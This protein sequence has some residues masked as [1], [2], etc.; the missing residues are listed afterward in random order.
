LLKQVSVINGIAE[1][2]SLENS[3][4]R[5]F[6]YLDSMV[7]KD[8]QPYFNVFMTVPAEAAHDWPDF[9]D[10]MSRQLQ[11]AVFAGYMTGNFP[12]NTDKWYEKLFS[13]IDKD[14]GL[15]YRPETDYS[16][17]EADPGDQA[18]TLF[19]LVTL[20]EQI[21]SDHIITTAMKMTDSLSKIIGSTERTD[22]SWLHGFAI[23]SLMVFYR[24][25][26]YEP[27]L[28]LA[29]RLTKAVTGKSVIINPE[30]KLVS[31]AHMHGSL[32]VLSGAADY[33]LY[34]GDLDLSPKFMPAKTILLPVKHALLWT[35]SVW[36]PLLQETD[37]RTIGQVL[38][39]P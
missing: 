32:R 29:G 2:F 1:T 35:T 37:T 27:A 11:A 30:N 23:K 5:S 21:K 15:L 39:G 12:V 24:M 14:S 33:A 8:C 13:Y 26:G 36:A 31:G 19:T 3:V 4:K 7:D 20:Y 18:L 9:G 25:T 16:R 22:F 17:F 38:K 34:T 28:L 6:N 10:V